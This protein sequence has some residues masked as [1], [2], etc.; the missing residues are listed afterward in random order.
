MKSI[1]YFVKNAAH[2]RKELVM[3][4]CPCGCE[5][6]YT[7]GNIVQEMNSFPI[8]ILDAP[9]FYCEKCGRIGYIKESDI[10]DVLKY[11]YMEKYNVVLWPRA[12]DGE[13]IKKRF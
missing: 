1:L 11:A 12:D 9:H 7:I 13:F 8:I 10:L 4:Q 3:I 5:M 6:E 2:R